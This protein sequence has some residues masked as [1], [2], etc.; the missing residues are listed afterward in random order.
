MNTAPPRSNTH[1]NDL[2][3]NTYFE[4]DNALVSGRRK[5]LGLALVATVGS[6][7][8]LRGAVVERAVGGPHA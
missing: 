8:H 3:E 1:N 5:A 4:G 7:G 6:V 2:A